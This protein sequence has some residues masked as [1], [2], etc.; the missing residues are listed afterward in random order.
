MA[1]GGERV[2][3]NTE[4]ARKGPKRTEKNRKTPKK[5]EKI[6]K[7]PIMISKRTHT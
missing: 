2:A 6:L 4:V 5:T 1:I 7:R 3:I